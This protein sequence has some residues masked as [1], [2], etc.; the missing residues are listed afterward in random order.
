M[1]RK[2]LFIILFFLIS[3]VIYRLHLT[4]DNN[5]LF[6]I[7]NA[8]DWVDVREMVL[9]QKPRLTGP[10]SAIEGVYTGPAWYYLL[11]IPFILSGGHPYGP[12]VMEIILWAVGGFFL[13][14]L[15]SKYGILPMIFAGAIW[16][17]SNYI[18]LAT[19]Y[20]FNPNPV[21]L[22]APLF[23]YLLIKYLE[24]NKLFYCLSTFLLG[25]LFFNFELNF[26]I[27]VVPII[28]ISIL[29]T[30]KNYL[31]KSI[32]F[33]L[34]F[35]VFLL[36]LLP[37]VL[38][39]LKHN[40]IMSKSLLRYLTD[41]SIPK[42]AFNPLKRFSIIY[43]AFYNVI[44]P[45]FVNFKPITQIVLLLS[46]FFTARFIL[47][48]PK[49]KDHLISIS[50]SVIL[51]PFVLYVFMPVTV[52]SWHLGAEMAAIIILSAIMLSVISRLHSFGQV[53]VYALCASLTF[54]IANDFINHLKTL[55]QKSA[56]VSNFGNELAAVD[57][58]YQKAEGKNF[59]VY[60]YIPSIIDYP[61]QYIFYWRGL[62]KYDYVPKDYA[63]LPGMPPYIANKEKLPQGKKPEDSGLVFLIK[64]N[65]R[66]GIRHLWENSFAKLPLKE[67]S[68][69]GPLDV[70][71]RQEF[72]Q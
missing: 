67:S 6:N 70:E 44:V 19:L 65:D 28:I 41:S 60:E 62:S 2:V 32:N 63:Y 69:V 29:L 20:S 71:I 36:T 64:E 56:D 51:V 14:K 10:T 17:Y 68:R 52:N 27:F 8:R 21:T 35:A 38:F 9:L 48:R 58:V 40:F 72:P 30:R 1:S 12:I 45:T 5:F 18:V 61:Y 55:N 46:A 4:W 37:Q 24:T 15:V 13:L 43:D 26:G 11:A 57:Y 42:P 54:Y 53:T 59:K 33:Y 22:L 23:I 47:Q 50:L 66:I 39:D 31:L 34:G 16:L 7:D 25:G 49:I 3:G